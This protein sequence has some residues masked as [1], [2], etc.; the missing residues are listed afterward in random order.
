MVSCIHNYYHS[1]ETCP[2]TW[3]RG[4]KGERRKKEDQIVERTGQSRREEE[5]NGRRLRKNQ[6]GQMLYPQHPQALVLQNQGIDLSL[7]DVQTDRK[8]PVI[9]SQRPH[10]PSRKR[11]QGTSV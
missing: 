2:E 3:I 6:K 10:V 4:L 1:S 11:E 7:R 8:W 9:R 5:E